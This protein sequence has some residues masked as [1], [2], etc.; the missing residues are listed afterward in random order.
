MRVMQ[1]A[2]P[3]MIAASAGCG[4]QNLPPLSAQAGVNGRAEALCDFAHPLAGLASR[5]SRGGR[6]PVRH[7]H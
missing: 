4:A 5:R 6:D 1:S 7:G 2:D 3:S